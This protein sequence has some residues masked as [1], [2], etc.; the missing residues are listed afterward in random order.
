MT[1]NANN[2]AVNAVNDTDRNHRRLIIIGSGPAGLTAAIY[3]SRAELQPLCIEGIE[4]GGQLM[5]TTEVENYPG[6]PQ[7]L[8]GPEM[9]MNFREQA[10]RF[11]T[12]FIMDD[13]TAVDFDARP[14]KVTVADTTYTADSVIV[15]TGAT[16]RVIGLESERKLSGHGVSYCATCDGFFFKDKDII[17]VGGGDSAMEEA[18]FLTKFAS[19][20]TIVHRRDQYRASKIML[21]RAKNNPKISFHEFAAVTEVHG[22]EDDGRQKMTG[23]TVQDTRDGS[24]SRLEAEGLFVA[25]GHDP[26]TKLFKGILEMDDAG[27]IVTRAP[28]THTNKEGVFACGDVQDHIY[29]QAVTA[30]GSGCASA[31]DAERYLASI[32]DVDPSLDPASRHEGQVELPA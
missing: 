12:E 11:G 15:S 27:Y 4:S 30:A 20:V 28:T 9:M 23:V 21:D 29:R 25:I 16:A 5:L 3:A 2:G 18:N 7:G 32:G 26:N 17:V 10:E 8:M 6:F 13:A 24:E 14:M 19:H 22:T 31:L 1:T